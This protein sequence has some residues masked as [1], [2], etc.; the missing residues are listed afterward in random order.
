MMPS[1]GVHPISTPYKSDA[2]PACMRTARRIRLVG[3]IHEIH[4][5]RLVSIRID[6]D[7]RILLLLTSDRVVWD[8]VENVMERS[9]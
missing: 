5:P 3:M 4:K 6:F 8:E 7:L 2:R 1:G 9:A